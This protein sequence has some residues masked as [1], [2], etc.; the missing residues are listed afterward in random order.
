M[1]SPGARLRAA[2]VE[3]PISIPGAFNALTAKLAERLGFSA[4]Y[5][6]GGALSAGWAGLPDIGLLSLTEF[7]EQA[8]VI[9]RATSLPLLCDAD[10]GFGE[11]IN[12]V[13]SIQLFEQAG[14][15]GVHLED[16]VLPKRCGHLTGKSLIETSA[17]TA[18]LRAAVE[19]RRDPDFVIIARTDARSVEGFDAAVERARAYRA[20]GADMIFP[21]AL[22]SAE[23]FER[24][25]ANV[26][27][28]K[29]A[30]MTE[31]GRSPL[32]TLD[33]LARLGYQAALFPL[34]AFRA[35]MRAVELTLVE[36]RNSGTQR[37][38]VDQM[39][40][41]AELYEL[42]GYTDW[43]KRDRAYFSDGTTKS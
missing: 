5:L 11:A 14:V 38:I 19:A 15:A 31:F 28:P 4:V 12:V 41:R 18:K 43:E 23:E 13:R 42:L 37:G 3:Q 24:F 16:Q 10:T 25:A 32:L 26:E 8:A 29:I 35:A 34:T 39:Q 30:N 1:P 27:G 36:L 2:W 33:E 7:V 20:A 17:M 21:E 9:A 6:S 40:T 22:E